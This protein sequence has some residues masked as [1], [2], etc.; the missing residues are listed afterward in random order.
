M[1]ETILALRSAED[2]FNRRLQYPYVLFTVEGEE[3]E[4]TE[5]QKARVRHITENRTSFGTYFY[6][7]SHAEAA[8]R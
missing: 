4:I 5:V 7:G 6:L 3:G 8:W 1:Q 2:R